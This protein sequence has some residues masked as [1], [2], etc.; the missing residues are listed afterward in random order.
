MAAASAGRVGSVWVRGN[1]GVAGGRCRWFV[2]CGWAVGL[3]FSCVGLHVPLLD[4]R[5]VVSPIL[6]QILCAEDVFKLLA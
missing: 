1:D 2:R 6:R 4:E 5:D 3:R